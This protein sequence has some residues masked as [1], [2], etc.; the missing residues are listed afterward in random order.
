MTK[1]HLL[2]LCAFERKI[3]TLNRDNSMKWKVGILPLIPFTDLFDVVLGILDR[4]IYQFGHNV[5]L[6]QLYCEGNRFMFRCC[7]VW[8][9]N[10]SN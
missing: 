3:D 10:L 9:K 8:I 7:Y 4:L 5:G 2:C 6:F 1:L